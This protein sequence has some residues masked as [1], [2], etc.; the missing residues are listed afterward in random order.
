MSDLPIFKAV[1]AL[2]VLD[3][4]PHNEAARE[5]YRKIVDGGEPVMIYV[6]TVPPEMMAPKLP[7]KIDDAERIVGR[8]VIAGG[9]ALGAS[10]PAEKRP[11]M[12]AAPRSLSGRLSLLCVL[13]AGHDGPHRADN[14]EWAQG[15]RNEDNVPI[16]PAP[17]RKSHRVRTRA[18]KESAK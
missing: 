10:K 11:A 2:G 9:V 17:D 5:L 6:T 14:R 4:R 18:K 12:C 7:A 13:D 16:E 1:S 8:A 3:L 15:Y